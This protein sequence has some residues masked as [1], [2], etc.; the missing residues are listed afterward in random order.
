MH[1]RLTTHPLV[2]FERS[3]RKAYACPVC[4]KRYYTE[5]KLWEHG[6]RYHIEYLGGVEQ[7][8]TDDKVRLTFQTKAMETAREVG[9]GRYSVPPPSQAKPIDTPVDL[10]DPDSIGPQRS[11]GISR[12]KTRPAK[13]SRP[14]PSV[15]KG[16]VNPLGI[17]RNRTGTDNKN[18]SVAVFYDPN[19]ESELPLQLETR[20][21][22][23]EQLVIEVKGIYVG[24]VMVEAKCID[25]DERQSTAARER[26]ASKRF[27][28]KND[29]W[30]S[31][32]ALHKQ[33]LHEHHNFFLA[34]HHPSASPALSRLAAKYSM[35]ARMWRHGIQ[36]F[37][38]VL[39]Q[40][41]PDSLEH[42]LAFIYIAYSMMV[43][44]YETV[45]AFED[46]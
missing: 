20:V 25:I 38:E 13:A 21:I 22:S 19:T 40:R 2:E 3:Q 32:I 4:E 33:L 17:I 30:Q 16:T 8:E 14:R 12:T 15:G 11:K 29:Q 5:P 1:R 37:L 35:P 26:D 34:S 36:A 39:R 41:L 7:T 24:L 18:D 10:W 46:T 9:A 31:L 28:L 44:L 23:Y 6:R 42:M 27:E 43:L 45:P